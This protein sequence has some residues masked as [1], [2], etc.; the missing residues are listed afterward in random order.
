[1][2]Y[3]LCFL[4]ACF[5]LSACA[6]SYKNG[7]IR[8]IGARADNEVGKLERVTFTGN[9]YTSRALAEQYTIYRC[10]E[11]AQEKGKPYFVMYD[12]LTSAARDIPSSRP[13]RGTI[14]KAPYVTAYILLLEFPRQGALEAKAVLAELQPV[15]DSGIEK[16]R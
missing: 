10:A 1:M 4:A 7:T 8:P 2:F 13:Q 11:L 12:S 6:E 16:K 9:D 5:C 3:R 15:I 14:K